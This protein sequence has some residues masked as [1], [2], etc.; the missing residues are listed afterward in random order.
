MTRGHNDYTDRFTLVA[1]QL[2]VALQ[3]NE[4]VLDGE[5]VRLFGSHNRHSHNTLY[6]PG[7]RLMY[8]V[9]DILELNR[10]SLVSKRWQERNDILL[11]L[12]EPQDNIGVT[13]SY[14]T[15]ENLFYDM[16]GWDLEGVVIKDINSVYKPGSRS[17]DWQKSKFEPDPPRR[18]L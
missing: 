9:F 16:H 5:M 14:S 11:D 7:G 4:A 2:P 3:G 1:D 13:P 6:K 10:K 18:H 8:Y 12:L 17:Q 15:P